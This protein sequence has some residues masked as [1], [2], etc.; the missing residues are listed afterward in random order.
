VKP[1]E[2]GKIDWRDPLN[3]YNLTPPDKI[4]I[5]DRTLE[6]W[7]T[8]RNTIPF[9]DGTSDEVGPDF[10]SEAYSE[11][12]ESTPQDTNDQVERALRFF[13]DRK[14]NIL[15]LFGQHYKANQDASFTFG[16]EMPL[17]DGDEVGEAPR[18]QFENG[19]DYC[20]KVCWTER[21]LSLFS[22]S[23]SN[24][25]IP[26]LIPH[27]YLVNGGSGVFPGRPRRAR[28]SSHRK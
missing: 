27:F 8:T 14:R 5:D 2:F 20:S 26:E 9:V 11:S 3:H 24:Q 4:E 10:N 7:R 17:D 6:R 12:F 13:V 22:S 16:D 1:F 25:Q 15:Q 18:S 21:P 19:E 28:E 23:I